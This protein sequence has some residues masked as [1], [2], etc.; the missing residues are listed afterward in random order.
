MGV[1]TGARS[2]AAYRLT[3][4]VTAALVTAALVLL[5]CGRNGGGPQ[6][7]LHGPDANPIPS[8]PAAPRGP[9]S[10]E[11]E[12]GLEQLLERMEMLLERS[13]SV[14]PIEEIERLG[15]AGDP[16]VL[17]LLTDLFPFSNRDTVTAIR[18]AFVELT[19]TEAAA[20]PEVADDG[21]LTMINRLIAWDV[22]PFPGYREYKWRLFRFIEP[23]WEPFFIDEDSGIDWR[24]VGWGGVA[25]DDR[26]H[27]TPESR[28]LR[29]CIPAIDEPAVTGADGGDW[30]PDERL[31][32]GVVV[33]GEARAYPKN[34]ME[35]HEMVN[36]TLGGR[37]IGMPYCTLCGSAQAY[38]TDDVEGFRPVLRTSGLLSRSN[39]LMYD[40]ST[41]SAIDTFSGA[42]LSG[43]LR[44]A[45]V[46]L[47][48]ISV[49]TSTWGDWKRRH[50]E[51]TI[52]ERFR[53]YPLDPLRGR[54][55]DGPIF[56]VGDVDQRLPIQERV[57]GVDAPDGPIA[58]P[59]APAVT[60]L[61]A[62]EAVEMDGVRLELEG[63]GVRAF[64]GDR[65]AAAHEAF[66]FA[67]SQFK[68]HTRLWQRE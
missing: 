29:G 5:S 30:Y 46:V 68:P 20:A 49:V 35:V 37:R 48:P 26:L 50:P 21:R 32:F 12:E 24:L 3:S 60:A 15:A 22:P 67:W 23:L 47:T 51:T 16:R 55:D 9:L 43:P 18:E 66:W 58:F 8:A 38:F 57:L 41:W 10:A 25:I 39:K 11:A 14:S 54:D 4:L 42:A 63:S 34:V 56:P 45:G 31:V 36:D 44:E 6:A 62:G 64:I 27:A 2:R 61:R 17:W 33:D 52:L 13:R 53:T 19:G 1:S 40:R 7:V 28:C 65:D 59:V